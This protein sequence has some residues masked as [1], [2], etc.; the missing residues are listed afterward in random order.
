VRAHLA[1]L[2][3]AEVRRFVAYLAGRNVE[4]IDLP[5]AEFLADLAVQAER[6]GR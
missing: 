2:L 5:L 3:D 6:A 1:A 4:A